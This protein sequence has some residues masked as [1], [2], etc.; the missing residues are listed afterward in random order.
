[1][2]F[3][4]GGGN[5]KRIAKHER[6]SKPK[7]P[8]S[9]EEDEIASFY[10]EPEE[11]EEKRRASAPRPSMPHLQTP[12]IPEVLT[13]RQEKR[14]AKQEKQAAKQE[15][16]AAK[17]LKKQKRTPAQKRR[18]RI[19]VLVILLA[20][21]GTGAALW[22]HY[23]K[24]P[25]TTTADG[26]IVDGGDALTI[27]GENRKEDYFTFFIGATDEDGT[28]TDS[29]ML[30]S[31]NIK[32]G[33]VNVL[34]IPRDTM[35]DVSRK[36]KKING[37]YN[38]GI[39]DTRKE[40]KQLVGFD[41]DKYIVFNFD[42]IADFVD[43]IGGFD[44][45]VP[46]YMYYDDPSQDLHIHLEKGKQHLDGQQVVEFLRWRKN[47][48]GTVGTGMD[49]GDIDRIK[50]Q[51]EFLKALAAEFMT[52][53]NIVKIPEMAE[54][55]QKNVE[56][57]IT[58]GQLVWLG[59]QAVKMGASNINMYVL[60]GE[61]RY[62]DGVSYY[63]GFQDETL[64]MLNEHFNPYTY[65]LTDQDVDI[66]SPSSTGRLTSPNRDN[67]DLGAITGE[68]TKNEVTSSTKK[69][70]S[71]TSGSKKNQTTS[72]NNSD[73]DDEDNTGSKNNSSSSSGG[74][75]HSSSSSG[76]SSSGS[77]SGS[78]SS[79][80]SSSGGSSSHPSEDPEHTSGGSGSSSGGSSSGSNSGSSGG[81][82]SGGSSSGGSSST[83]TDP[84]L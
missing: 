55:I 76:S 64:D 4:G 52:P 82:E 83:P 13:P 2:K 58:K 51:Q 17:K 73:D 50:K 63:V 61:A 49:G 75:N 45:D 14:R 59:I 60:P 38:K 19:L 81:G 44:Y 53:A 28:R 56:S 20:I 54:C 26:Q 18:K 57:D 80:S 29:M 31:M 40:I 34:N 9:K 5:K 72:R 67:D 23:V 48:D 12:D 15:K 74:K 10:E 42:A 21:I 25:V 37:A 6:G 30:V 27:R 62:I 41:F 11:T 47:N 32:D 7:E 46:F 16:K 70:R 1:M 65:E 39:E 68:D 8:I 69:N 77:S 33:E 3:Y 22:H 43:I 35:S 79:G 71:S 36:N 78:S 24:P 84:E 66:V